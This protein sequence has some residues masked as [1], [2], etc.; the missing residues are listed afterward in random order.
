MTNLSIQVEDNFFTRIESRAKELKINTDELIIKALEHF[1]YVEK[2]HLL[3]QKLEIY[4]QIN[5]F[6]SEEDFYNQI[7]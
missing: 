2:L 7:S 1:L 4:A 3:R 5:D 6:S